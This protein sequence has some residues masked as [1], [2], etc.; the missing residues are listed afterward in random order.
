MKSVYVYI[1]LTAFLFG[2]M[3]V[4]LKI[5]GSSLDPMQITGIRFFIAGVFFLPIGLVELKKKQIRLD[6]GDFGRLAIMGIICVPLCMVMFQL[7][8]VRSN[9]STAAVLFSSNP[10]FTM[11]IAHF[12][13]G[14]GFSKNKG[15]LTLLGAA[16]IF[17]MIRPWDI[18][19]GN[20]A[21]GA[22]FS[23]AAAA[24][25]G[26]HTVMGKKSIEKMG[27]TAHTGFSFLFGSSVLFLM[28]IPMGRPVLKGVM[29][30]LAIIFYVSVVVTALGFLFYFLAIKVSDATT[31]SISFFLKIA[32]AP[33]I[34]VIVMSDKLLWNSYAAIALMLLA[35]FMNLREGQWKRKV[36]RGEFSKKDTDMAEW[37]TEN[38]TEF[39]KNRNPRLMDSRKFFAVLIPLVDVD[40]KPH[41]LFESRAK[42]LDRQPGE[43]CFPGGEVEGDESFADCAVRETVEE[44]GVAEEDI[45]VVAEADCIGNLN[46]TEI[47]CFFGMIDYDKVKNADFSRDEVAEL[48][49]VPVKF[50]LENDPEIQYVDVKVNPH[51]DFPYEKIGFEDS[52]PWARGKMEVPVYV[53]GERVIW[54]LTGRIIYNMIKQLRGE[55]E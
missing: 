54:G 23:I 8:I 16:G 46:S 33:V 32:I 55:K 13:G 42:D 28:M 36:E 11:I 17:M 38:I 30:N 29:Q 48:F 31:G 20:S 26:L 53:Y 45:S 40:G 1:L 43:V 18:Q 10:I 35:S 15:I 34:A 51:D 37:T 7:G 3:E 47:H 25:F 12:I 19:A 52:Y 50:F 22:F 49:T 14:E 4:S 6:A 24:L 2:T 27:I 9:A 21:S 44:A 5:G 41:L 39:Y